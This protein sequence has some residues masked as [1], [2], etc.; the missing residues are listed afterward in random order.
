MQRKWFFSLL[1]IV[2]AVA[3]LGVGSAFALVGYTLDW[4]TVD[5]GGTISSTGGSYNLGG[6]IGQPDAGTS[7]GGTYT[8]IG[9][10]WGGGA[11]LISPTVV[12]SLLANPNPTNLASVDFTVTFSE[13]VSGVDATDFTLNITGVTGTSITGVS[14]SGATY[15]VTVN[16]GSG[17]GTIRLDV[18]DDDTILDTAGN[19]LSGGYTG[20]ETYTITKEFTLTI[21]SAHGTVAKNPDQATYHEGDVVQLTAAPNAGWSF[22]NW[23]GGLTG[24]ANPGSVTIHGNTS[25]TANYTPTPTH[26]FTPTKTPTPTWTRTST[27]TRTPTPTSTRSTTPTKTPTYTLTRTSTPS[28][29]PTSTV[30]MTTTPTNTYRIYLPLVKR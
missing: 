1:L 16:T 3:L 24:S 17:N 9:G 18:V 22:A 12:S 25:V 4:W 11:D 23:T 2:I 19:P 13:T 15:T 14:G 10:F 6:T 28:N 26:T 27:P 30:T 5:G 20:G 8:L 21:V 7:G 29:T